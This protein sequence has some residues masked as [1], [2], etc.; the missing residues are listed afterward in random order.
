MADQIPNFE[1]DR[2]FVEAQP[3]QT[4][5]ADSAITAVP[6]GSANGTALSTVL[7]RPLGANAAELNL[8]SGSSVTYTIATAQPSSAPANVVT[9]SG[10]DYALWPIPL[11][12]NS[13]VYITAK[14]GSPTFRWI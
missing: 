10:T 4:F 2:G 5:Y 13:K 11:G 9:V 1:G 7:A 8:P 12:P 3:V 14:T 6:A